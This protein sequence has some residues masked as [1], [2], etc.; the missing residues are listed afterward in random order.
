MG[1]HRLGDTIV[2]ERVTLLGLVSQEA[3]SIA[4]GIIA[5]GATSIY[6]TN[7]VC[8]GLVHRGSIQCVGTENEMRGRLVAE[9]QGREFIRGVG[10]FEDGGSGERTR[11][12]RF[13][14]FLGAPLRAE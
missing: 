4:L 9:L 14:T 5:F 8:D 1:R 10:E 6:V 3:A 7:H 12:G 2:D 13:Q 11:G